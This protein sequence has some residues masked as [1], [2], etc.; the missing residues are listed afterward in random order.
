M[1]SA[2]ELASCVGKIVSAGSVFG[3][4]AR[5]MTKY[6]SIS[7]TAAEDWDSVSLLD[8][9]CERE[10]VFWHRNASKLNIKYI[11]SNGMQKSYYVVYSDAS[12]TGCSAHLDFNGEKVSHREWDFQESQKSSTWR[13]LTAIKF[14]SQSF[15]PL[16]NP[17]AIKI[18][19]FFDCTPIVFS[20]FVKISFCSYCP[21][22]RMLASKGLKAL[23]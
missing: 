22:Y 10:L 1:V 15:L 23:M 21:V 20:F 8:D 19:F 2:R 17:L 13:E 3:N 5:L 4:I 18:V 11:D 12:G 14:A 9:F 6:C 7:I 16:L